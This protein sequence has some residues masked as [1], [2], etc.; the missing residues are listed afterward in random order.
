MLCALVLLS[1]AGMAGAAAQRVTG[2]GSGLVAAPFFVLA[3]GPFQ[4]VL[5]ANVLSLI[6]SV[7]ILALTRRDVQVGKALLLSVPAAGL[8]V[9]L[10]VVVVHRVPVRVLAVGVALLIIAALLAVIF[11]HRARV[12]RGPAGAVAAGSLSGFMNVTAGV[13]GPAIALYAVSS[14]W[15]HRN[16]VPT[17]QLYAIVL[18][19]VSIAAKGTLD[20]PLP[21][22]SVAL[23]SM[24]IGIALGSLLAKVVPPSAAQRA[25]IGLAFLGALA[26]LVKA[27]LGQ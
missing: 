10:G 1:G 20:I 27:L 14:S 4:G 19:A 8:G 23:A 6:N 18:N 5:L 7:I 26:T 17:V 15:P 9:P 12:F 22:L 24:G 25:F 11:S 21:T 13:G 3:L 2:L 16:L